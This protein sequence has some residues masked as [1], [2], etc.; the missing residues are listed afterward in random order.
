MIRRL[1]LELAP[2]KTRLVE[3]EKGLDFLGVHF[4]LKRT[5]R[6]GT[7]QFC[8]G[9]PAAKGM[10]H[11]RQRVRETIGQDYV[12]SLSEM[13]RRLNPVLRGWSNYYNGLNSS[14][15]FQKVDD[16]VIYKLQRWLRRKQQR[17]RRAFRRPSPEWFHEQG[18]FKCSGT[19]VHVW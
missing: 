16:Y 9:F 14:K 17:T 7:K 2:E 10:T 1:R 4:R 18:L 3:A 15:H 12:S 19:I 5:R 8:Y 6:K 13:I 11:V